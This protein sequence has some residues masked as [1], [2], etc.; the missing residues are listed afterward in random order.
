MKK[1]IILILPLIVLMITILILAFGDNSSLKLEFN[2]DLEILSKETKFNTSIQLFA[3]EKYNIEEPK[4]TKLTN[5]EEE[6]IIKVAYDITNAFN[7]IENKNY[8]K[9]IEKYTIR[10]PSSKLDDDLLENK[11]YDEWYKNILSIEAIAWLLQYRSYKFESIKDAIITYYSDER[12]I[13]QVYIDNY[14][15][16]IGQTKVI[17]DAI[18]EYEIVYEEASNM[19]KIKSLAVE[20]VNDLEE[21]YQKN[22]YEERKQNNTN[23]NPLSNVSSYIPQGFTTFDYTKLKQL[24]NFQITEIYNKNKNS[25]AIIDSASEGGISAGSATGF[26]IRSGIIM[27]SYS[28]IYKMIENGAVR[29]YAVDANDKVHEIEGIVAAYPDINIII[30][31]LKEEYGTPVEIGDSTTLQKNDPIIAISS[32]LGLKSSIKLGIYFD[33]LNDD[34]KIIRTSLPLIDG[35]SGSALFNVDGKVIAI[36]NSVT[37]NNSNYN[38]GLNNSTEISILSEIINKLNKEN[39]KEITSISLSELTKEE[40]Y[41]V[42]NDV[43]QKILDKYEQLPII[44][45]VVPLSLYSAY[46]NDEYLIIRYKQSKYSTLSNNDVLNIYNKYLITNSYEKINNNVYKKDNITIRLKNNLGYIIVIIEG[47]V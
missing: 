13:V 5:E 41:K 6:K 32:S 26:Y 34:Y 23:N 1:K 28:S 12:S 42:I 33:T 4:K 8:V 35:D 44:T 36:N 9:E 43:D 37:E 45:N 19:Y 20:W 10:I 11:E 31:K 2:T 40:E 7:D 16:F 30:L 24:S 27:T 46:T 38:S 3:N 22:D 18:F 21:Y 15:G 17:M 25:I 39:F 29:Y 47:V 14:N